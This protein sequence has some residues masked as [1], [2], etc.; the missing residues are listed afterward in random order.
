LRWNGARWL[1][2]P[3][4]VEED[5]LAVGGINA[6]DV[7]A[8]GRGGTA[9]HWR[10]G[11]SSRE[12]PAD[13][14]RWEAVPMDTRNAFAALVALASD[15]VWAVGQ[16]PG[17]RRWRESASGP[18]LEEDGRPPSASIF[19]WDGERWRAQSAASEPWPPFFAACA[20][21]G[22][23][24]IWAVGARGPQGRPAVAR[25]SGGAWGL[26]SGPG[27]E[28]LRA[29]VA[30]DD[31]V[32]VA[33]SNAKIA[34]RRAGQW[35]VVDTAEG[36]YDGLWA[37]SSKDVWA[38]GSLVRHFDGAAWTTL[39]QAREKP[40]ALHGVWGVKPNE[41]WAVGDEGTVLHC[42]EGPEPREP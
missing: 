10:K 21:S 35:A 32:W 31:Q 29:V 7:W 16:D 37:S 6:E 42:F 13:G 1:Q 30:M 20:S 5:L 2:I 14:P 33:S 22:G 25:W 23:K 26:E 41:V 15:D 8:V 18:E 11:P 27:G 19:H 38:V 34:A 24:E 3:T 17:T 9:L 39:A 40:A 28:E 36:R 12:R 4:G